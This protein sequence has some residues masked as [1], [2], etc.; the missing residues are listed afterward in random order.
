MLAARR[1]GTPQ[2][3]YTKSKHSV[4]TVS[5]NLGLHGTL[6]LLHIPLLYVRGAPFL[7]LPPCTPLFFMVVLPLTLPN[8]P[9]SLLMSITNR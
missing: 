2:Q 8:P 6:P 3:K 1:R 9:P 7:A 5:A 4:N